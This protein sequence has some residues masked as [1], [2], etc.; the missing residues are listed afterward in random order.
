MLLAR[1]LPLGDVLPVFTSNVADLLRL[2]GKGRLEVGAD[3]DLVVLDAEHC[4]RDV[5]ARGRAMVRFGEVMVRGMFEG[6]FESQ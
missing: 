4:V 1:G 2:E 3:A 5:Y 6:A